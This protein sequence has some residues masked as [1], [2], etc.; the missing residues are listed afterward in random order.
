[1][2]GRKPLD[3]KLFVSTLPAEDYRERLILGA[4][5]G[6]VG[7]AQELVRLIVTQLRAKPDDPLPHDLR[8]Y[9][10]DALG[11]VPDA[12]ADR[13]LNL[14]RRPGRQRTPDRDEA[15]VAFVELQLRGMRDLAQPNKSDDELLPAAKKCAL[16]AMI[17]AGGPVCDIRRLEQILHEHRALGT[18]DAI[19]Q[20][21]LD[22]LLAV[23]SNLR[24]HESESET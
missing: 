16:K 18:V 23:A 6:D 13:A 10:A 12:S 7:M 8:E 17:A 3:R 15:V 14:R 5:A 2:Q 11:R 1:M 20:L 22:E 4:K 24:P 19:K 21:T 9:L